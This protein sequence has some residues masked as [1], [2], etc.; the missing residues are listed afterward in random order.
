MAKRT[1]RPVTER[2]DE[3]ID[4]SGDCWL[5]TGGLN[6]TGYGR[7]TVGSK[8]DGT[9]RVAYVH[10]LNGFDIDHLCRVPACCRPA[11]LDP[12]PRSVNALRGNNCA[13]RLVCQR[14]HWMLGDNVRW[15]SD[16]KRRCRECALEAASRRRVANAA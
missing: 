12:V 3:K 11:H 16:G 8:A 5:W 2:L 1:P 4:R 9:K 14:G 15:C 6:P 10:R 13:R 7:L